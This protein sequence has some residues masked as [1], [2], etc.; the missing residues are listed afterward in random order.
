[1]LQYDAFHRSFYLQQAE[2]HRTAVPLTDVT[3]D[4]NQAIVI[5]EGVLIGLFVLLFALNLLTTIQAGKC[6][7]YEYLDESSIVEKSITMETR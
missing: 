2:F 4:S 3:A 7:Q 5:V 6:I 1:M